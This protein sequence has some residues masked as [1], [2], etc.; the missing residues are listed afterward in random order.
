MHSLVLSYLPVIVSLS[1]AL[2]MFITSFTKLNKLFL[3]STGVLLATASLDPVNNLTSSIGFGASWILIAIAGLSLIIHYQLSISRLLF[4][5]QNPIDLFLAFFFLYSIFGLIFAYD[6]V[7]SLRRSFSYFLVA[8]VGWRIFGEIFRLKNDNQRN[9]VYILIYS[10]GIWLIVYSFLILLI[11]GPK[12]M[13]PV[14]GWISVNIGRL[15]LARLQYPEVYIGTAVSSSAAIGILLM[16][17]LRKRTKVLVR[18][19]VY[20]TLIPPLVVILI[21]GGGENSDPIVRFICCVC[22]VC[23]SNC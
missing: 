11:I 10:S 8:F 3:Y 13:Q 16:W 14:P 4:K 9:I 5:F 2:V 17:H 15:S 12:V 22:V 1:S 7:N 20:T 23:R 19:L 18:W 6:P 21:W